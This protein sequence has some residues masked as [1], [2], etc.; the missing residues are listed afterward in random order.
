MLVQHV[1]GRST[2]GTVCTVYIL[3][4]QIAFRVFSFLF[5]ALAGGFA[6]IPAHRE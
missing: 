4:P 1:R 5:L 6:L 3:A 2:H